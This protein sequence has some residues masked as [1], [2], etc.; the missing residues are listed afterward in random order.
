MFSSMGESGD[1][2]RIGEEASGDVTAGRKDLIR[3]L[4]VKNGVDATANILFVDSVEPSC[5]IYICS[6]KVVGIRLMENEKWDGMQESR[7]VNYQ[8][9]GVSV[10]IE[11]G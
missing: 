10:M 8:T 11:C 6:R 1:G 2:A 4:S 3:L 7:L 9:Y 5:T